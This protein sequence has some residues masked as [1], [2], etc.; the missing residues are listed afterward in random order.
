MKDSQWSEYEKLVLNRLDTLHQGLLRV[1]ERLRGV[2]T[3]IA[4]LE[5]KS[6]IW[7]FLAG[8]LPAIGVILW[9]ILN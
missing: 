8:C 5:V 4:V 7:G 1:E 9:K 2:E 3:A 6:G